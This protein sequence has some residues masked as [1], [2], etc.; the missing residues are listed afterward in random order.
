MFKTPPHKKILIYGVIICFAILIIATGCSTQQKKRGIVFRGDWAFEINRTPWVGHP[1]NTD[2]PGTENGENSENKQKKSL[3]T[4]DKKF[5]LT[6]SLLGP[7]TLFRS[8]CQCKDCVAARVNGANINYTSYSY[9]PSIANTFPNPMTGAYPGTIPQGSL[10]LPPG[11]IV[12]PTGVLMPN[13]TLLPHHLFFSQPNPA[14]LSPTGPNPVGINPE[15]FPQ[16]WQATGQNGYPAATQQFSAASDQQPAVLHQGQ[17]LPQ[18][19]QQQTLPPTLQQ[20]AEPGTP[21]GQ[22]PILTTPQGVPGQPQQLQMPSHVPGA[23]VSAVPHLSG[24]VMPQT[25]TP[26]MQAAM[27]QNNM[28]QNTMVQNAMMQSPAKQNALLQSLN[29]SNPMMVN[30]AYAQVVPGL[31]MTGTQAPGYPPIGYAPS[32]Y[33][34]GYAQ[35]MNAPPIMGPMGANAMQQ[36]SLAASGG[37]IAPRNTSQGKASNTTAEDDDEPEL[38]RQVASMPYPRHFP[39]PTRPVYQR[40]M[41]MAPDYAA[42]RPPMIPVMMSNSGMSQPTQISQVAALQEQQMLLE[43]QRQAQIMQQNMSI[44]QSASR[45]PVKSN[46]LRQPPVIAEDEDEIVAP[47]APISSIML[48]NHQTSI[49]QPPPARASQ[50]VQTSATT[51]TKKTR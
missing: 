10:S 45:Q 4:R 21:S 46:F 33:A 19:S 14:G 20:Q 24:V 48:A 8:K 6:D 1:G 16:Q 49:L 2:I 9:N 7:L 32:G 27:M 30:P 13:G 11:A 41:G 37:S 12:V 18:T 35:Q 17:A 23:P 38:P 26:E 39:V 22:S 28:A 47:K 44:S 51:A 43:R 5:S 25:V 42:A 36:Q 31:S 3:C 29:A 15:P 40:N 50:V 34:P